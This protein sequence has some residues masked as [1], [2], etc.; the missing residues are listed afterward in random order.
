M[1]P[2]NPNFF[3]KVDGRLL[4]RNLMLE[5]SMH[6]TNI[7]KSWY[8][9]LIDEPILIYHEIYDCDSGHSMPYLDDCLYQRDNCFIKKGDIV[10]DLGANIGIFSRFASDVGA[11]K[12]YSFEPIVENFELLMLNRPE[13]CEP[14]RIAVSNEDNGS[15]SMAYHPGSPGGSSFVHK[16]GQEQN[17][18]TMTVDTLINNGIIEQPDFIKMDIEGAEVVAFEGISDDVLRK[19][20]CLAMEMHANVLTEEQVLSIYNR[21]RS[22]GFD[23][24]T[25]RNPDKCNIVWFTNENLI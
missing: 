4:A 5:E 23:D 10:L 24:W 17:V 15:I 13:N 8:A 9:G 7:F 18:M 20:R 3:T 25:L 19:T 11:G 6:K 14:H 21:L 16:V 22:L 1:K 12:I 2:S